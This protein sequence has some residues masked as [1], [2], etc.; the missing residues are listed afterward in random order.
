MKIQP[1]DL[2]P[3]LNKIL[4]DYSEDVRAAVGESIKTVVKDAVTKL[5]KAGSFGGKKY[6]RTWKS[7]IVEERLE[8]YAVI[9][10]K[11]AGLTHLLEFGHALYAGGRKVGNVQ[12]FEHIAPINNEVQTAVI[13]EIGRKINDIR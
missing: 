8:T 12:A 6:R 5:K 4:E 13:E 9:Y 3:V 2:Q 1:S 11:T 10:N 7:K